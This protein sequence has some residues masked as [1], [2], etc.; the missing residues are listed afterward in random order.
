MISLSEEQELLSKAETIAK[1]ISEGFRPRS[2]CPACLSSISAK[3][4]SEAENILRLHVAL[5]HPEVKKAIEKY[6][7]GERL[8]T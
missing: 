5:T 3:S 2:M 8:V 6:L 4:D 7:N 1:D